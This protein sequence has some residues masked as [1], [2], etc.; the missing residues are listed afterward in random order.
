[1]KHKLIAVLLA[2]SMLAVLSSCGDGDKNSEVDTSASPIESVG[3]LDSATVDESDSAEMESAQNSVPVVSDVTFKDIE[4][5]GYQTIDQESQKQGNDLYAY[6]V[7]YFT[8]QSVVITNSTGNLED[9]YTVL[10]PGVE[11]FTT[12]EGKAVLKNAISSD[13]QLFQQIADEVDFNMETPGNWFATE[14]GK[15]WLSDYLFGSATEV[16]TTVVEEEANTGNKQ[17]T[18]DSEVI[19]P[20]TVDWN[21][22]TDDK[23]AE[24]VQAYL[25][26]EN[27][28]AW[29]TSDAAK[30]TELNLF[31][32]FSVGDV[33]KSAETLLNELME[34]K[35]FTSKQWIA[36]YDSFSDEQKGEVTGLSSAADTESDTNNAVTTEPDT[37]NTVS[38][39][40]SAENTFSGAGYS[41]LLEQ[42]QTNP[43]IQSAVW[44]DLDSETKKNLISN[45]FT[46]AEGKAWLASDEA[47]EVLSSYIASQA[48]QTAIANYYSEHPEEMEALAESTGYR[49]KLFRKVGTV[50]I[51]VLLIL[52]ILAAIAVLIL[53]FMNK[54]QEE[55]RKKMRQE[56]AL[57]QKEEE[58][59]K[60][61]PAGSMSA[62]LKHT[63][64]NSPTN[65]NR[66]PIE[67]I[68]EQ[69][70]KAPVP[71]AAPA[72]PAD[73]VRPVKP[74]VPAAAPVK[75]A[76]PVK[77]GFLN[78]SPESKQAAKYHLAADFV[79]VRLPEDQAYATTVPYVLYSDSTVDLNLD[80]FY[81]QGGNRPNNRHAWEVLM[82]DMVQISKCFK[83]YSNTSGPITDITG[84]IG[85]KI[86]KIDRARMKADGTIEASGTIT[87]E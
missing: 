6:I 40:P 32:D 60:A 50:L 13:S 23:K 78:V 72:R 52:L 49:G 53:F 66:P 36:L 54:K 43:E 44:N 85:K 64:F 80:Y 2:F 25:K 57:K 35:E 33:P 29:L 14:T 62:E 5:E 26:T 70:P 75:P 47:N 12:P 31:L 24:L 77:C 8:A 61:T 82:S 39:D 86:V 55:N 28:Q 69:Q 83:L 67:P 1:M 41:W 76:V 4:D 73:P 68:E 16:D 81:S 42:L 46:S 11:Y 56:K 20:E 58:L 51:I 87:L 71:P 37:D 65:N 3:E 21:S 7:K 27:G 18:A 15:A 63:F 19:A 10:S 34:N 74:V 38:T 45:F 17:D 79:L 59:S 84:A 22:L 9:S 48:G 30:E